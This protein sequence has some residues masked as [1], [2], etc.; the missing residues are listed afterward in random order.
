MANPLSSWSPAHQK[1]LRSTIKAAQKDPDSF[2][3]FDGDNTIWKHDVTEGMMAWLEQKGVITLDAFEDN[4]LP[5]APKP[6]ESVYGYYDRLCAQMGHSACYLWSAQAFQGVTLSVMRS[7]LKA[8][9]ATSE[10]IRV[11]RY[12]QD[13]L[14]T[15]DVPVPTIFTEQVE[16]ISELQKNDI[17]V[18]VVSASLEELVRM[19]VSDPDFGVNIPPEKVIGVNM[20]IHSPDGSVWASAQHRQ[21]G[22]MGADYFTEERLSGVLSHHIYA[23]ATW[24]AGKVAAIQEWTHARCR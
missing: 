7:E 9:M 23:P 4:L 18:W 2:V 6:M 11:T 13:K 15:I 22:M 24:Y 12:H 17:D 19:V 5:I 21:G 14:T 16:L 20:L 3:V 10:P 1:Q 8:M